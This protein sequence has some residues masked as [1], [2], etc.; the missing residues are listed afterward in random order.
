ME[1]EWLKQKS[2]IKRAQMLPAIFSQRELEQGV[3]Q[4]EQNHVYDL[5]IAY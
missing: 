5:H 4:V 3:G 1:T 2:I